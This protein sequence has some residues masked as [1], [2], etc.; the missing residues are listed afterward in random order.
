[1]THTTANTK[2]EALRPCP[3][4]GC[5]A[6]AV[7]CLGEFWI[8]CINAKCRGGE[9][10]YV[11]KALAAEHWNTRPIPTPNPATGGAEMTDHEDSQ[12]DQLASDCGLTPCCDARGDFVK[13]VRQV[14]DECSNRATTPWNFAKLKPLM[15]GRYTHWVEDGYDA[16]GEE[17]GHSE[18]IEWIRIEQILTDAA[19]HQG[20]VG[21]RA[22][23]TVTDAMV[24]RAMKAHPGVGSVYPEAMRAAILAALGD[25]K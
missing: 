14:V 17:Q 13:L 10:L 25:A 5:P 11:N 3:F 18:C 4:C 19:K 7:D 8:Q 24:E 6:K 15:E 20:E 2:G 9:K 12:W 1:M 22:V 23:V 21:Q 16:D